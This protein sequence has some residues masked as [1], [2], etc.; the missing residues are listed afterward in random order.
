VISGLPVASHSWECQTILGMAAASGPE[1]ARIRVGTINIHAFYD[2]TGE[3]IGKAVA[4][5]APDVLCLN[6]V[7]TQ[8]CSRSSIHTKELDA[9]GAECGLPYTVWGHCS[10][11]GNAIL[12]RY[13]I[14]RSQ[15]FVLKIPGMEKRYMVL[16]EIAIP[17]G[18]SP[19][20]DPKTTDTKMERKRG[21]AGGTSKAVPGEYIRFHVASIHLEHTDE[22]SRLQQIYAARNELGQTL[23]LNS[24]LWIAG[25]AAKAAKS[26][27]LPSH[28]S[29]FVHGCSTA[30]KAVAGSSYSDI[31]AM[32]SSRHGSKSAGA[33]ASNS[34]ENVAPYIL[35]GDMNA[36][37]R[38]DLSDKAYDKIIA[39]RT[40]FHWQAAR[41][42]VTERCFGPDWCMA[43]MDR[44][45]GSKSDSGSDDSR[46][47]FLDA[48]SAGGGTATRS[49]G[50]SRFGTRIDYI[51]LHPGGEHGINYKGKARE[52]DS[53]KLKAV[54]EGT[55]KT[56]DRCW[57]SLVPGSY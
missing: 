18:A 8:R 40:R 12:S 37:C 45:D 53:S 31:E 41:F 52:A 4:K 17:V 30:L 51:M 38:G 39:R 7:T 2:S 3:S 28:S 14:V 6:E 16:A 42:E 26:A 15:T 50:T 13:P 1:R 43:P 44:D 55:Y 34:Q 5:A 48:V 20:D 32:K 9:L 49:T 27:R 19:R 57:A 10:V 46:P 22:N 25:S 21:G 29:L 54:S 23:N 35:C 47:W 56:G 33:A 36:L 11:L 24:G